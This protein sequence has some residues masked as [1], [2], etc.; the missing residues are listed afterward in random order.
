MVRDVLELSKAR[1]S[2]MVV[3]TTLVGFLL[4]APQPQWTRLAFTLLGTGLTAFGAAALN[5]YRERDVDALMERTRRRPLPAGRIAP[6]VAL[7]YGTGV[8]TLGAFVLLA[9]AGPLPASLAAAT[10]LLYVLVYTPLKR[11]STV[12]TLV[13]A[14]CGAIPP[15][16]GWTAATGA[17]AVG[18]WLLFALLFVWQMPHF[19][20][21]AWLYRAD[22]ARG[23]LRM[24]PVVDA[25]GRLTFPVTV[26]FAAL[27]LPL[28]LMVTLAGV[29]GPWFALG[30]LGLGIGW[31]WLG[32]RLYRSH[33]DRDARRVFLASLA[34]L[35]LVLLLMVADRGP[36]RAEDV[37]LRASPV[38][39]VV[40]ADPPAIVP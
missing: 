15:L 8:S 7:A 26:L 24:L 2:G 19:L 37:W 9:F 16:I 20:S 25:D 31:G 11:I 22:Y 33:S 40:S 23:G 3:L 1:L 10:I 14:V 35:P 28:G 38:A 27:H 30:S 12:N 36:G 4:G 21:L 18:G 6:G 34:Y 17:F 32:L 5:Q 39:S 13:G 29:A